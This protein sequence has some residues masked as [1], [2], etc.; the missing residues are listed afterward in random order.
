MTAKTAKAALPVV[1]AGIVKAKEMQSRMPSILLEL[2]ALQ[3]SHVLAERKLVVCQRM[4]TEA[5]SETERCKKGMAIVSH[6]L[7]IDDEEMTLLEEERKELERELNI[8]EV[9]VLQLSLVDL[10]GL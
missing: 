3:E 5:E 10:R 2:D 4:I 9:E 7:E 1:D 6:K 8:L